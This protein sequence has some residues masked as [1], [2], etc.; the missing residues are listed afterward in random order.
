M[1]GVI[2]NQNTELTGTFVWYNRTEK[3]IELVWWIAIS[4]GQYT[5]EQRWS[6][7]QSIRTRKPVLHEK[8]E[9]W[10]WT[11]W[12]EKSQPIEDSRNRKIKRTVDEEQSHSPSLLMFIMNQSIYKWFLIIVWRHIQLT[13]VVFQ[14]LG[15]NVA[16]I[17]R[18]ST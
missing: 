7:E 3:L 11:R 13:V 5:E 4:I 12:T 10:T 2:T 1:D 6:Y 17:M 18:S 16:M 8:T 14:C 15:R 9:R